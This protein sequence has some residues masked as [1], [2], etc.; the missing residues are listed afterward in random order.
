M[1]NSNF[2]V[3]SNYYD[4]LYEDKNY[5]NDVEYIHK[6]IQSELR[7]AK[8]ILEF[9]SGTGKH[10]L[11]IKEKGYKIIGLEKSERMAEKAIL[12]G[13]ECQV[14]DITKFFLNKSYDVVLAL[15]NLN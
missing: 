8:T 14:A 12:S 3:Y 4:L 15:K 1:N 10:G 11:L 6:L 5:K 13:Y 2:D 9:G 7:G